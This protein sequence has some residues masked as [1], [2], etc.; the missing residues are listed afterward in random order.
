MRNEGFSFNYGGLESGGWSR[1][2]P[3]LFPHRQHV[4][5]RLQHVHNRPHGVRPLSLTGGRRS[6]SLIRMMCWKSISPQI[7]C[8]LLRFGTC[9]TVAFAFCVARAI[10]YRS[11]RR[12]L[13]A[14]AALCAA[15]C[16]N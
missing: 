13:V 2:R 6:Q 12:F 9:V 15:A 1:V 11:V 10:R 3:A 5:N 16:C 4:R 8:F 14:S 7:A